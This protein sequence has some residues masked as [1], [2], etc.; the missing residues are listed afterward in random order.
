MDALRVVGY[1]LLGVIWKWVMLG[2]GGGSGSVLVNAALM[3]GNT[4][5]LGNEVQVVEI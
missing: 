1:G 5:K 2:P 4:G 3:R